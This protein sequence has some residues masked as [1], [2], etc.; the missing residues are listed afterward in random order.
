MSGP[1]DRPSQDREPLASDQDA[2]PERPE[3]GGTPGESWPSSD[4]WSDQRP[5]AGS[6]WDDWSTLRAPDDFVLDEPVSTLG[7]PWAESW[8]AE[9]A[10]REAADREAIPAPPGEDR[11]AEPDPDQ[12]RSPEPDRW[13][14]PSEPDA[15]AL[16]PQAAG[17]PPA[18][19]APPTWASTREPERA[20]WETPERETPTWEAVEPE[21]AELGAVASE[22]AVAEPAAPEPAV[23]EPAAEPSAPDWE[24]EPAVDPWGAAATEAVS[25]TEPPHVAPWQVSDDPWAAVAEPEASAAPGGEAGP[26]AATPETPVADGPEP[27]PDEADSRAPILVEPEATDVR[28]GP[29]ETGGWR[30]DLLPAWLTGRTA[31]SAADAESE[32]V[33]DADADASAADADMAHVD[34]GTPGF[35]EVSV[36][37]PVG[38]EAD[39][40]PLESEAAVAPVEFESTHVPEP[41]STPIETVAWEADQQAISVDDIGPEPG[42]S[43]A[44]AAAADAD[45]AAELEAAPASSAQAWPE[46]D[47]AAH[48]GAGPAYGATDTTEDEEGDRRFDAWLGASAIGA[49]ATAP[50]PAGP[51]VQE[52]EAGVD[53]VEEQP[54]DESTDVSGEGDGFASQ[55]D[56]ILASEPPSPIERAAQL[57]P[58]PSE[59]EAWVAEPVAWEMPPGAAMDEPAAS[60]TRE[61]ERVDEPIPAAAAWGAGAEVGAAAPQAE[62]GPEIAPGESQPTWR[63]DWLPELEEIEPEEHTQVLP[64]DWTPPPVSVEPIGRRDLEPHATAARTRPAS[65]LEHDLDEETEPGATTAE[66]AVPWL[67]G[68]ILLLAG[69]VI[70]L[71]AL[72]FAGDASLGGGSGAPTPRPSLAAGVVGTSEPSSTPDASAAPTPAPTPSGAS[73]TPAPT[74]AAVGGPEYGPIELVFQG[75]AAALAPIYLLHREFTTQPEPEV[76]AQDPNLD[77]R[78]YAWSMDGTRGAGMYADLLVSIEAGVEKRQLADEISAVTFGSTSATVYATRVTQDGANDVA[79]VLAIDFESGDATELARVTYARPAPESRAALSDAQYEDEG[80]QVRLF[81]ME[82]NQL[83][84]WVLNG[85]MWQI[86]PTDGDVTETERQPP[87][88]WSPDGHQRIVVTENGGTTTLTRI[89]VDGTEHGATTVE[90]LVSHVRWAAESERIVFTLG[91]SATGG[92]VLQDL[93]LWDLGEEAPTQITATGAAF[94][95]EW[96]GSRVRWREDSGET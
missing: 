42:E 59:D 46:A 92:G 43:S 23:A 79:T 56:E 64:T 78:R 77:L 93:F 63:P 8:A 81:W 30:R 54:T 41:G 7:D 61:P 76:L 34:E 82:D 19:P 57:E 45:A 75:R 17:P 29:Q 26:T 14:S 37:E 47:A 52:A 60:E 85:G 89:D 51:A 33:A 18:Q 91:R 20:G 66:Q 84:L 9:E 24:P 50:E 27:E 10:A 35:G 28:E 38:A 32:E 16:A 49:A 48:A 72:I 25:P 71:L 1:W 39:V 5:G 36:E 70:V 31:A 58:P 11:W 86:D 69:M 83:R 74:D 2:A 44:E 62:T 67:I 22:P 53:A 4:L 21:A 65:E 87:L 12:R 55:D 80:G 15:E 40:E 13:A 3:A 95:A 73:Q 96:M 90:G 6:G 68:F 88:L 94:G